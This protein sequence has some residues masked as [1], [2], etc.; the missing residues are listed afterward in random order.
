MT[1]AFI[2]AKQTG[3]KAERLL[4]DGIVI[5]DRKFGP[6]AAKVPLSDDVYSLG[7]DPR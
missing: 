5:H 6:P 3:D 7:G 1:L 4:C 2:C